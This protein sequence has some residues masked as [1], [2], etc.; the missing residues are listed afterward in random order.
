ML[1]R[2]REALFMRFENKV[3]IVTGAAAGIGLATCRRFASEGARVVAVDLQSSNLNGVTSEL[4]EYGQDVLLFE[5][6]CSDSE[7]VRAYVDGAVE[8][9]GRVDY[10]FNN[11]GIEGTVADIVEYPEEVFNRVLEVNVRG[12][13]L[14]IKHASQAMMLTGGGAIVNTASSAGLRGATGMSAYIASK[15][16]VVGL[17]KAAALELGPKAIRVNAV[18]PSPIETRMMRSIESGFGGEQAEI[19][20]K[21]LASRN[22]LSRYGEPAEVASLVAFLCSDDASYINGGIYTV[23]GGATAGH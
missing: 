21:E 14:G 8:E 7:Q 18:C 20:R 11:A 23:D 13:W 5:A 19:V 3:V 22:P 1:A 9:F 4:T 2:L 12:V 15:H 17:T 6:D 16:A 10:L